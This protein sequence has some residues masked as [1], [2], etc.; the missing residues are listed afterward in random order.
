MDAS[1]TNVWISLAN[2]AIGGMVGGVM[3]IVGVLIGIRLSERNTQKRHAMEMKRDILRRFT[4]YAYRLTTGWESKDDEPFAALNQAWIVFSDS[5]G[6]LRAIACLHKEF[7]KKEKLNGKSV[8]GI[9]NLDS[10]SSVAK[11]MAFA[12]GISKERVHEDLMSSPF[13]PKPPPID[14]ESH[15]IPKDLGDDMVPDGQHSQ[16]RKQT[17]RCSAP[18][19]RTRFCPRLTSFLA[20]LLHKRL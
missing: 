7:D 14:L 6:V 4:G 8:R 13:T 19:R 16:T 10:I 11:S 3:A 12:C 17:E 18:R 1:G 2:A 5:P 20:K 15:H 9:T